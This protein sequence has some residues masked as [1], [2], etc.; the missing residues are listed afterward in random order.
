M[1]YT[2]KEKY[3]K[4]NKHL[5]AVPSAKEIEANGLPL[6]TTVKGITLNV[7]ENS[8]DIIELFKRL[9]NLEKE[10][11]RLKKEISGLKK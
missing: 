8:L 10:N 7:E 9:E 2:T 6:V 11:D 5:F 4:K 1:D 3:F